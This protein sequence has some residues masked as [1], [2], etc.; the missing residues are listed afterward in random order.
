VRQLL[1]ERKVRSSQ[2]AN[3]TKKL[4]TEVK[5]LTDKLHAFNRLNEQVGLFVPDDLTDGLFVFSVRPSTLS[6]FL[7]CTC[8]LDQYAR[9]YKC[10]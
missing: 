6:P 8:M 7:I 9:I 5:V 1:E 4:Q 10:L 2:Y 3:T